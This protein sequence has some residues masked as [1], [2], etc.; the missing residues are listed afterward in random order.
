MAPSAN[1]RSFTRDW[2]DMLR[3]RYPI[4]PF[5]HMTEL[6]YGNDPFERGAVGW[7]Q[8]KVERLVHDALD[9]LQVLDKKAFLFLRCSVNVS[10]RQRLIKEGYDVVDEV[11]LC[12]EICIGH[13]FHKHYIQ[14]ARIAERAHIVFDQG[15][16]FYGKFLTRWMRAKTGDGQVVVD[17]VKL[18]WD[19]IE[20]I[21]EVDSKDSGPLQA[22]DI[23]AWAH[24]R[25]LSSYDRP[26][27][28]LARVMRC[29]LPTTFADIG[30]GVMRE[31]SKRLGT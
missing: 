14:D 9:V 23:L 1:W 27:R 28:D 31:K 22:A 13:A 26:F 19:L 12:T 10:A 2:E 30:E 29:I 7:N 4:A 24:S 8:E 16:P 17:P 3:A 11:T 21:T 5:L 25:S 15:E 20:S 18:F 6:V